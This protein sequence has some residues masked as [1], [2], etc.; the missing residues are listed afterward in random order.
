MEN[1]IFTKE[2]QMHNEKRLSYG[3]WTISIFNI[4]DMHRYVR[5]DKSVLIDENV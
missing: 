1:G 4:F 2:S 3:N 5:A